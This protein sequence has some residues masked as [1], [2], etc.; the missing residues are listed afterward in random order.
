M[1]EFANL[2]CVCLPAQGGAGNEANKRQRRAAGEEVVPPL[3]E[4]LPG[5]ELPLEEVK[6]RFWELQQEVG[7]VA[8]AQGW[9]FC[10]VLCLLGASGDGRPLFV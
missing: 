7:A 10:S 9:L 2:C 4:S 3:H 5:D 1:S 8:V 6:R